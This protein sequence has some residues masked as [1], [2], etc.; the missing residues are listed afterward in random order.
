MASLLLRQVLLACALLLG[1]S[2]LGRSAAPGGALARA[3]REAASAVLMPAVITGVVACGVGG[4]ADAE[5]AVARRLPGAVARGLRDSRVAWRLFTAF[6]AVAGFVA[7]GAEAAEAR[8]APLGDACAALVRAWRAAAPP[9]RVAVGAAAAVDVYERP[10]AGEKPL[11]VIVPGGSWSHGDDSR[12]YR[13]LAANVG[14]ACDADVAVVDYGVWPLEDGDG[15]VAGVG[16]ALAWA[17]AARPGDVVAVGLSAGAHL[18]AAALLCRGPAH[19]PPRAAVLCSGVYDLKAH[20]AH[21]STRGVA[22]ISALGGA[23]DGAMD[24]NSPAVAFDADARPPAKV[25][26]VHGLGDAT[27]PPSAADAL[28]A[29]LAARAPATAVDRE[30]L[31]DAGHLDYAFRA[32]YDEEAPFLE[33]VRRAVAA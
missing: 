30:T 26:V 16:A 17:D 23:F 2:A 11:V 32:M 15:M 14:D 31:P 21:E 5:G 1:A 10:G 29:A 9:R 7:L 27:A 6:E 12:L 24:R 28:C 8:G 3:G 22:A 18:V 19:A 4:A 13:L 25:T 33:T 20:Y